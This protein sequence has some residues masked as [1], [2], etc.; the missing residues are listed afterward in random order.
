ML[1]GN[2]M[3]LG[4]RI[5]WLAVVLLTGAGCAAQVGGPEESVGEDQAALAAAAPIVP[6]VGIDASQNAVR[7]RDLTLPKLGTTG[8]PLDLGAAENPQPN[9]WVGGSAGADDGDDREPQLNPWR[10]RHGMDDGDNHEPQPQPWNP[11]RMP[12]PKP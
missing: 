10:G 4:K 2:S 1:N 7:V 5:G 6:V 8:A 12:G 3:S 11:D 9:P